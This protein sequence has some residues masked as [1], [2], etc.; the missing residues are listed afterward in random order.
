MTN[1][2]DQPSLLLRAG[3]RRASNPSQRKEPLKLWSRLRMG[4]QLRSSY[5]ATI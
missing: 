4:Y 3:S 1:S 5:L 2:A